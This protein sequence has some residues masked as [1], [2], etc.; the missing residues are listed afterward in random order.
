MPIYRLF[1]LS[2]EG[3]IWGPGE[4]CDLNDDAG[5]IEAARGL[6]HTYAVEVWD[7]ARRV[8]IVAPRP[9][10]FDAQ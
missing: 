3:R 10:F 8:E 7:E 9:R 4:L 6:G 1:R 2:S 5:A